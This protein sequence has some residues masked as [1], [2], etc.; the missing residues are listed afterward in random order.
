[1]TFFTFFFTTTKCL[2][3]KTFRGWMENIWVQINQTKFSLMKKGGSSENNNTTCISWYFFTPKLF[4]LT[5]T[6][7]KKK[8]N[9][10]SITCCCSWDCFICGYWEDKKDIQEQWKGIFYLFVQHKNSRCDLWAREWKIYNNNKKNSEHINEM[11]FN[12]N[13]W[14]IYFWNFYCSC[15][16]LLSLFLRWMINVKFYKWN[17]KT[18]ICGNWSFF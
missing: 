11:I 16:L 1:M 4:S 17:I 6:K 13:R 18:H 8:V 12:R 9:R 10:N 15:R 3:I 7:W 2:F 5:K 14:N